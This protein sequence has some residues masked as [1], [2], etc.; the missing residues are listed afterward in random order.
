MQGLKD[1]GRRERIR[2]GVVAAVAVVF[3]VGAVTPAH[4]AESPVGTGTS[5]L[6][7]I[8]ASV[9]LTGLPVDVDA[10]LGTL[11]ADATN[12]ADPVARLA[13]AGVGGGGQSA[14]D[15]GFTS[16]DGT[17]RGSESRSAGA[18]G[19][20]A[21]VDLVDYLVEAGADAAVAELSGLAATIETPLA[22][23]A[24]A[25]AQGL[26][27]TVDPTG[28][29]GSIV[30]QVSGLTFGLGDL[31][32]ADVLNALPLTTVLDLVDSLDL[33]V[34]GDLLGQIAD[35]DALLSTL[36]TAVEQAEV[37]ADLQSQVDAAASDLPELDAVVAAEQAVADA[38]AAVAAL[39]AQAAQLTTDIAAVETEIA[40]LEAELLSLDPILDLLRINEI[41]AALLALEE[42]LAVLEA[43]LE[44]IETTELP[45]ALADLEAALVVLADAQ[46][47][48]EAALIEL[49]FGD[50]LA[51]LAL[52]EG[53]LGDLLDRLAD[54]LDGL[55]LDA[56]LDGLLGALTGTPLLDLG[57]IELRL[58]TSADGTS[59]IGTV[60]C[61]ATGLRV[62]DRSVATP[63]CDAVG[64]ALDSLA[65]TITDTLNALP[66]AGV[67]PAVTTTGL[68]T[69]SSGTRPADAD[70]VSTAFARVSALSLAIPPVGLVATTDALVTELETLI[71]ELDSL[72][73]GLEVGDLSTAQGTGGSFQS[74]ALDVPLDL[75]ASLTDLQ[76]TLDSLPTGDALDGLSTVGVGAVLG[77][78][79]LESS[80]AASSAAAPGSPAAPAG[81]RTPDAPGAPVGPSAPGAPSAPGGP[82]GPGAPGAPAGPGGSLPR[83]GSDL[84]LL[85]M[86]AL[87]AISA[88]GVTVVGA[89]GATSGLLPVPRKRAG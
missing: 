52:V 15:I 71:G 29:A 74:L 65:A 83:T 23:G 8:P 17:D 32:P 1:F 64:A 18:G 7:I 88:G 82:G 66:V 45:P 28:T 84:H 13:L 12:V 53:V 30:L 77:A 49:G 36:T 10:S 60:T 35:I 57:S 5:I 55:D 89:R 31:L 68:D 41:N 67:V 51:E 48:L 3:L 85:L 75:E 16:A 56:L 42:E 62:L 61:T 79:G 39:E 78:V 69:S 6:S 44:A 47:A 21:S 72:L 33:P 86:A 24:D 19:M 26:R 50:L 37:L 54:L 2:V 38:E 87:A 9:D 40:A 4:T 80:F 46:A 20:S 63:G 11:L 70:G 59:S 58:G 14:P 81:P 34:S 27:V 43:E 76:G 73:P 22:L 25:Q